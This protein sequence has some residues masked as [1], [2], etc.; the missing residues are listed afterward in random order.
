MA[1]FKQIDQTF[2]FHSI[3]RYFRNMLQNFDDTVRDDDFFN[4]LRINFSHEMAE[5]L[6]H[7]AYSEEEIKGMESRPDNLDL[8]DP[9]D[10]VFQTLWNKE[11]SRKKCRHVLECVCEY[12]DD[13]RGRKSE[14]IVERR[15]GE[16]SKLLKLDDVERDILT[17]SYVVNE[18][19]FNW[20]VRVENRDKPLYYAMAIDRSMAEVSKAMSPNGRLL[21]Y[22]LLDRD[23][24]FNNRVLGGYMDGTAEEPL[25]RRFYRKADTG[26]SLPWEY[27]GALAEGEG[28]TLRE[29]LRRADGKLNVLLYGAPGTGKTSFAKTLARELGLTAFEV[30]QGDENGKKSAESRIVGYQICNEQEAPEKSVII[31]DEADELLR[32][33]GKFMNA[34]NGTE[35]G[36]MNSLLDSSRIPTIWISNVQARSM[37]ES[38]RRRFDF[39]ILF[40]RLNLAQRETIWH[41]VAERF[42][43][44]PILSADMCGRFA[45]K[46]E[47]SAGGIATV[48][49]NVRRLMPSADKVEETVEKLMEAHCR[50]MGIGQEDASRFLPAKDYSLDGLNIKGKVPLARIVTAARNYLNETYRTAGVDRPRLNILLHGAPGTGKTEFVKYLAKTL[51]RKVLVKKG[52]D[53][54]DKYVG[55]SEKRIADAFREAEAEHA[56]LFFDEIDGMLQ[57]RS[58]AQRSWEITQVNEL[59]QQM[60]NFGGIMVAATNFSRNLDAAVMR[61]FTFKLEFDYLDDAGKRVFFERFFHESLSEE[62]FS[63]LSQVPDLAPG[64][65][66]T[67]RQEL[68]YLGDSQTN[69]DR[70][71]ALRHESS[72]KKKEAPP[73]NRIGFAC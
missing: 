60:E 59:L 9:L 11:T 29:L 4:I 51:D 65:F 69:M 2:L 37:D 72:M 33:A 40:E 25:A 5:D 36:V 58:R 1:K 27:Y 26:D 24:D 66:R 49:A 46:Y 10:V 41:N 71:A 50:L 44:G 47:T 55:E 68:Y 39:S 61:R 64:D 18:T 13:R 34:G 45:A 22:S 28:S 38:V 35:K 20:P 32:D 3:L 21:K 16:L 31:V 30:L 54:L 52:S 7:L 17:L 53:L 19:C 6:I 12:I 70:I 23:W 14:D 57:D 56:I 8:S 42:E 48:M 43:L 62:E 15:L 63:A 67:V 73:V